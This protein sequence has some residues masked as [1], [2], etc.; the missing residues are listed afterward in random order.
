MPRS[1]I[2]YQRYFVKSSHVKFLPFY[3]VLDDTIKRYNKCERGFPNTSHDTIS[4]VVWDM[5][6][7]VLDIVLAIKRMR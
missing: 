6:D 4:L 7:R 1:K 3:S 5:L 2:V